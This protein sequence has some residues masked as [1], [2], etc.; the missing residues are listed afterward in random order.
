MSNTPITYIHQPLIEA[1]KKED[2][3]AQSKLYTLYYKAIYNSSLR[4]V[5]DR[6]SAEDIMQDS[7]I[8]G[9][10]NIHQFDARSTFGAWIK[11]IAINKSIN[12]IKRQQLLTHKLDDYSNAEE[13][14][15]EEE[16]ETHSIEEVKMAMNK[17]APNYKVVFS[18][19]MIEGYDHDEIAKIMDISSSTSRS[20][21]SRAK[22]Q[23]KRLIQNQHKM[24]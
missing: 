14:D 13:V 11:K 16:S 19:Y 18:L 6:F 17:L 12:F 24:A 7:F 8:D 2:R 5:G 15:Q 3:N 23:V 1:A 4:I 9:F 10:K 21:L 20:Q 22:K